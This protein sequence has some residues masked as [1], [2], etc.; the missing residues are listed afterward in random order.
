MPSYILLTASLTPPQGDDPLALCKRFWEVEE[1][2]A[3]RHPAEHFYDHT[4]SHFIIGFISFRYP[5]SPSLLV[6]QWDACNSSL[7]RLLSLEWRFVWDSK[8]KD[9]YIKHMDDYIAQ[10]PWRF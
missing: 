6:T 7:S 3:P 8:F 10:G 2:S 1:L 4:T 5:F 9:L